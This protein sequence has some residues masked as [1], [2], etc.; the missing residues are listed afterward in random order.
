MDKRIDG[1]QTLSDGR[2]TFYHAANMAIIPAI[3]YGMLRKYDPFH[4]GAWGCFRDVLD[5]YS[6]TPRVQEWVMDR[7]LDK[8]SEERMEDLIRYSC[9]RA[10][11]FHLFG[12]GLDAYIITDE[13]LAERNI[14]T[15][16]G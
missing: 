3:R 4:F 16:K 6:S 7:V 2:I 9:Q 5:A 1:R 14:Q 15:G 12:E 11:G 8:L 13:A 10:R